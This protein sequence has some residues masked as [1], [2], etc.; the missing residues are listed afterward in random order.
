M[1]LLNTLVDLKMAIKHQHACILFFDEQTI[2]FK[3]MPLDD[4]KSMEQLGITDNAMVDVIGKIVAYNVKV[5]PDKILRLEVSSLAPVEN[6]KLKIEEQ[7]GIAVDQQRL[8]F[9]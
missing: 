5:L 3:G 7:E 9:D 4:E 2:S 8:Y 6:L 1:N